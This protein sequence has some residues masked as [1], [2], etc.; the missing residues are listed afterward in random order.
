[1]LGRMAVRASVRQPMCKLSTGVRGLAAPAGEAS[2]MKCPACGNTLQE[3]VVAGIT[4][5]VCQ[6]GCGGIWF[7]RFEL[8]K[9]DE[10]HEAAGE[11]LLDLARDPE[12]QVEPDGRRQCPKCQDAIMMRHFFSVR[13]EI[14]VDECPCC[15]GFWLDYGELQRIREQYESEADRRL[16]AQE[17]FAQVFDGD[18]ARMSSESQEK[19]TRARKIAR[20]FR[21]VCPS[22]YIPGK[23]PWGA[24]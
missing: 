18:L 6:G 19:L 14:E 13:R 16:A 11:A 15:A 8:Q 23:Q 12:L 24:H 17:L 21:F 1:M 3:K 10:P 22:Y 5:D 7:D 4:L 2:A 20:I 9:V